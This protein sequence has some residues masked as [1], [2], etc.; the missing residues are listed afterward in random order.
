MKN[1]LAKYDRQGLLNS[2]LVDN[3]FLTDEDLAHLLGVSIQTIRLDRV[4]LSIPEMRERLRQMAKGAYQNLRSIEKDEIV[5]ELI[6]LEVGCQGMSLLKVN[7]EMTLRR[8]RVLDGQ[9]LFAQAH[10][11]ALALIDTEIALTGTSKVSFKRPVF[12]GEKAVAQA[13][14][15]RKSKNRYMVK[16]N[17]H[18]L[19]E[20][21]FKGKFLVFD[22]S[23][24]VNQLENSH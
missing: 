17:T 13:V 19:D 21:V 16:V 7:T 15:T 10:S 18:V 14:I 9:Y 1:N 22:L 2:K 6:S 4:E 20:L 11:L 5:G 23:E 24:E 12:Q 3:P 8:T